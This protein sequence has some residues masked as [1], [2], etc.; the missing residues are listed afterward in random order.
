MFFTYQPRHTARWEGGTRRDP[1]SLPDLI[2]WSRLRLTQAR[3][4]SLQNSPRNGAPGAASRPATRENKLVPV[5]NVA[6][7]WKG[8][9]SSST[10]VRYDTSSFFQK[11]CENLTEENRRKAAV[12]KRRRERLSGTAT[13]TS[14]AG[15]HQGK[16]VFN[17]W[18]N[19]YAALYQAR[20]TTRTARGSRREGCGE[21]V[22]S[23]ERRLPSRTGTPAG[24][25]AQTQTLLGVNGA[26][27]T[28]EHAIDNLERLRSGQRRKRRA[29]S[30]EELTEER[31]RFCDYYWQLRAQ[32][33]Q[34][35]EKENYVAAAGTN[36][37]SVRQPVLCSDNLLS[38]AASGAAGGQGVG[39][40]HTQQ[41]PGSRQ[42]HELRHLQRVV[43]QSHRSFGGAV[44]VI[45]SMMG[46]GK[47]FRKI[48]MSLVQKY[49]QVN[50]ALKEAERV[51]REKRKG[52]VLNVLGS[53]AERQ[54]R[55]SIGGGAFL[56]PSSSPSGAPA[57]VGGIA[58]RKGSMLGGGAVLS[59][60]GVIAGG[61]GGGTA[62]ITLANMVFGGGGG[63]AGE[64]DG[65]TST[66]L[67]KKSSLKQPGD[68]RAPS[69]PLDKFAEDYVRTREILVKF[70]EVEG[71]GD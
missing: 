33:E 55:S 27:I 63:S 34:E 9:S 43:K 15:L 1:E 47:D 69:S 57:A 35:I 49:V 68:P 66:A 52:F 28:P 50:Q 39:Q 40:G 38:S 65:G 71:L 54:R 64:N 7:C 23:S 46:G 62:S 70:G 67:A 13:A 29:K 2:K 37:A 60:A 36:A 26:L 16:N 24:T 8:S 10:S 12:A 42:K 18:K 44:G 3:S 45:G 11:V 32:K 22:E 14:T 61:A 41:R 4:V 51:E 30:Q 19:T 58:A 6:P 5:G 31:T 21:P 59:A 25:F 48:R 20:G 53:P 17:N 56:S